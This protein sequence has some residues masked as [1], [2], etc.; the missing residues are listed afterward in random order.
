M[1]AYDVDDVYEGGVNRLCLATCVKRNVGLLKLPSV[2]HVH[3]QCTQLCVPVNADGGKVS[4]RGA[5]LAVG[6]GIRKFAEC[7]CAH[8]Q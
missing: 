8:T 5:W 3:V 7:C 6:E 2:L 4:R 1:H